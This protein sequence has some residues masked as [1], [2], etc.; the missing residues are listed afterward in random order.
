MNYFLFFAQTLHFNTDSA[1][2]IL[3]FE[4]LHWIFLFFSLF[5]LMYRTCKD[6]WISFWSRKKKR[7][8]VYKA[9]FYAFVSW[10]GVLFCASPLVGVKRWKDRG[11]AE[12]VALKGLL[13]FF[14]FHSVASAPF[15]F[16]RSKETA[17]PRGRRRK[18]C[19]LCLGCL[20]PYQRMC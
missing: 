12:E 14:I 18:N 10:F 19:S 15:G 1:M 6:I 7:G 13:R 8:E 11:A 20:L 4:A 2:K 16:S 9:A 17:M 3:T 5:F